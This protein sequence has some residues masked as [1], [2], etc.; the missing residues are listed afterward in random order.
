[1]VAMA[2]QAAIYQERYQWSRRTMSVV[3]AGVLAVLVSLGV[4]LPLLPTLLLLA[5][6]RQESWEEPRGRAPVLQDTL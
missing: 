5:A 1:M 2:S 3:A 6:G 4:A